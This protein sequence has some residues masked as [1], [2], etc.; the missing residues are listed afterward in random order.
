M[1]VKCKDNSHIKTLEPQFTLI[2]LQPP[3]SAFSF[4]SVIKPPP[5]FKQYSSGLHVALKYANLHIPKFTPFSF[6]VGKH[7]DL[8]NMTKPKVKNLRKLV[9][10]PNIP[11]DQ[12][13][14]QIAN[15]KHITSH[16]DR[17]W[18]YY[19]GGGSGSGL[20]LLIAICSLLYWCCKRTQKSETRLLAC[21]TI[22][23]LE[24][25][26]MMHTRVGTIGTNRGSVSGWET[27]GIQD[28]AG[29]QC[30]VLSNDMQFAF[31]SALLDQLED[32]G[33]DVREHHRR[34][35]DRHHTAKTPIEEKPSLEIQDV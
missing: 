26:N 32:Y 29:T 3:C 12:L 27:V 14:A 24:S 22:A 4:S 23:D 10:A 35:R 19:V 11:I 15:F 8:S 18:I 25:P 9:Q 7:F 6:R 34:L 20:I 31:A 13:R 30:T 16:T 17:P 33:T 28:P 1:E 21:V 5:Y 2:N